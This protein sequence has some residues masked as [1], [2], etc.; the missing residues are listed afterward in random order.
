MKLTV[1][2]EVKYY[3]LE[4]G[5]TKEYGA[6]ELDRVIHH[7]LKRILMKELLKD[8]FKKGDEI[9]VNLD[10]DKLSICRM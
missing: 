9:F 6:R 10:K 2:K 7:E 4:K 5:F 1:T 8:N 3:L